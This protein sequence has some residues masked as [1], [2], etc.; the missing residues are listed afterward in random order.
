MHCICQ[1][2][3]MILFA[4]IYIFAC[5]HA[6]V[7][8]I[9][10]P[11]FV[12]TYVQMYINIIR[13]TCDHICLDSCMYVLDIVI[14]II[15]IYIYISIYWCTYICTCVSYTFILTYFLTNVDVYYV[16]LYWHIVINVGIHIYTYFIYISI[17][18]FLHI[19]I[20]VHL[21]NHP[22]V[23][24]KMPLSPLNN[25][26]FGNSEPTDAKNDPRSTSIQILQGSAT[27]VCWCMSFLTSRY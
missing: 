18:I 5:L 4:D 22:N 25:K 11:L 17:L 2:I 21:Q 20:Y 10:V 16:I 1:C 6:Y 23:L 24:H 14:Y 19:H 8:Y 15:Y 3:Y 27:C 13:C 9:A 7:S 12:F 26:L